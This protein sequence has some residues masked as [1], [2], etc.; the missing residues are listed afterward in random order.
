MSNLVCRC[1]FVQRIVVFSQSNLTMRVYSFIAGHVFLYY[2]LV[3]MRPLTP[4]FGGISLLMA[5]IVALRGDI[6]QGYQYMDQPL[7][8]PP[9]GSNHISGSIHNDTSMDFNW[10]IFHNSI[11]QQIIS[12]R[13]FDGLPLA[14]C[15]RLNR[16]PTIRYSIGHMLQTQ[17]FWL[18]LERCLEREQAV[19]KKRS[20]L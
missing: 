4:S 2:W 1:F 18:V 12:N 13:T 9:P 15:M 19:E 14:G 3:R 7:N 20:L 5:L 16:R 8:P 10:D 17:A 11:W 6:S